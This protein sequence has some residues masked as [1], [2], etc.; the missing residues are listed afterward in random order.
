LLGRPAR[1]EALCFCRGDKPEGIEKLRFYRLARPAVQHRLARA[2]D[3]CRPIAPSAKEREVQ[4][5]PDRP[6]IERAHR[7]GVTLELRPVTLALV[8][9]KRVDARALVPRQLEIDDPT[10]PVGI[11]ERAVEH[12]VDKAALTPLGHRKFAVRV[13]VPRIEEPTAT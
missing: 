6:R 3:R 12:A 1:L 10:R 7:A 4:T 9:E 13:G 5:Q 8:V 11:N 2:S